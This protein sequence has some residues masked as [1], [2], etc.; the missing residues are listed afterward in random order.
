MQ[1]LETRRVAL[2]TELA[3]D[4]PPAPRLHPNLPKLYRDKV[5]A[6]ADALSSEEGGAARELVRSLV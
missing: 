6:L 2:E 3:G 4:E 5:A 1:T